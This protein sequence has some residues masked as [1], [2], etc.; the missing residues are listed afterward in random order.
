MGVEF[1]YM[2]NN[3]IKLILNE[4]LKEIQPDKAYE[5]EIFARLDDIIKKI[6]QGQKYIKAILGGSGAKGTWLKTFDADIFVLFDYKKY[7]DKS[8]KISGIFE[9][10]LNKKFKNIIKLHGSRDYFQIKENNFTFEIVPILKI[11]KADQAKNIT[12]VS[13]LHS[14]W[15]KKHKKL[16]NEIKLTK[17]FAQANN[18][19]GAESHIKGFSGYVCEILT[20][21]YSSFLNLI[22][23]SAKWSDKVVVDAEKYYRGKDVFKMVNVSK[24]VSPLIVIDPVQKGRNAAAALSAEKFEAFKKASKE[25]SKNPSNRFFLKKDLKS[26]FLGLKTKDKTLIIIEAVPLNGKI[27]VVGSKL[28][29]IFEFLSQQFAKYDF[30]MIKSDWEWNKNSNSVFYF[31]FNKGPLQKTVEVEGPPL[32]MKLHVDNF[33]KTHKKTFEKNKKIYAID[34]RKYIFPENLLKELIKSDYSKERSK[35]LK[36]KLL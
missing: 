13:P 9:K 4:V 28:M 1:R 21:Y 23:N 26:L 35:S 34:E 8:D 6:N 25:F 18:V 24:L 16:V 33:K 11:N 32:E 10:I 29:K 12:D 22:K 14:N 20:V 27:D 2:Q 15:V 19:Y 3:K 31:I 30:K 36:I 5:N 7:K 17:Q